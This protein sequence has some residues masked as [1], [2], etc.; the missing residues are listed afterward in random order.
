MGDRPGSS[1]RVHTSE[2]KVRRK[3]KCWSVRAVYILVKPPDVSGPSL[4]EVGRY[5]FLRVVVVRIIHR[6][7]KTMVHHLFPVET[8][9]HLHI[10]HINLVVPRR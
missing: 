1:S 10:N 9:Y 5:K 4:G 3:D 7:V 2:D 8:T 6:T